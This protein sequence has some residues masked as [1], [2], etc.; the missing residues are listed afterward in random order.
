MVGPELVSLGE[1]LHPMQSGAEAVKVRWRVA[2]RLGD[3]VQGP[4]VAGCAPF[5]W[6]PCIVWS[7]EA[8]G[9]S[10]GRTTPVSNSTSKVDVA[11][12]SMS[13]GRRLGPANVGGLLPV[14]MRC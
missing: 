3:R 2:G 13:G 14:S 1:D 6:R 11:A 7:G 10:D 8:H 9:D 12:S 4:V 5:P